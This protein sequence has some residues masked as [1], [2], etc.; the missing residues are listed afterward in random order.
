METGVAHLVV[1]GH[2]SHMGMHVLSASI[3]VLKCFNFPCAVEL[4]CGAP[5]ES[6]LLKSGDQMVTLCSSVGKG[7]AEE[8]LSQCLRRVTTLCDFHSGQQF[9]N[10]L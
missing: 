2:L 4:P 6:S 5:R 3:S 1:T 10:K 7:V 8:L 9:F